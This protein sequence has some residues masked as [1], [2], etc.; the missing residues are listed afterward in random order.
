VSLFVDLLPVSL[1]LTF[2]QLRQALA[3]VR[4]SIAIGCVGVAAVLACAPSVEE[5]TAEA[6]ELLEKGRPYE[7]AKRLRALT[8]E[9]PKNPDLNL[10]YG[11]ALLATG[12]GSYAI[13]PLRI[14]SQAPER[15]LAGS[16]LLGA[17]HL[18]SGNPHDVRRQ[19]LSDRKGVFRRE[20]FGSSFAARPRCIDSLSS[21][22]AMSSV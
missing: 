16:L 20:G 18:Q 4:T 1:F 8:N 13:W 11:E 3:P 17:A 9:H 2:F 22:V 5:R 15:A 10:M 6:R 21:C 7:A 19:I 12:L 14:A